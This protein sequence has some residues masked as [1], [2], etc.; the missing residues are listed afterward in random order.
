MANSQLRNLLLARSVNAID[1]AYS[2]LS[3]ADPEPS[4]DPEDDVGPAFDHIR[5]QVHDAEA[6]QCALLRYAGMSW[7]TIATLRA[8]TVSRQALHR[9]MARSTED[10]WYSSHRE[11]ARNEERLKSEIAYT[12]SRAKFLKG[13]TLEDLDRASQVWEDRRYTW[14][15]WHDF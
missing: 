4:E 11:S 9:R 14:Y 15:W 5:S 12:H 2:F 7:D 13:F 6:Q 10:A 1:L 3:L 8:K